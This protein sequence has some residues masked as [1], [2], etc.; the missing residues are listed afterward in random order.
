MHIRNMHIRCVCRTQWGTGRGAPTGR[1][2]KKGSVESPPKGST[3]SPAACSDR[4]SPRHAD[5]AARGTPRTAPHLRQHPKAGHTCQRG[6]FGLRKLLL[7][8]GRGL[9][10]GR[11]WERGLQEGTAGP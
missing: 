8:L 5:Q 11:G 6:L 10:G 7:G 9:S 4:K 3:R 2:P 1:I